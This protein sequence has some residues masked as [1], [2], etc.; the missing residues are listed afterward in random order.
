[1]SD[2]VYEGLQRRVGRRRISQFVN[3]VVGPHLVEKPI[4]FTGSLADAYRQMASD[5]A[6]E[7]EAGEW[8]EGGLSEALP[9]EDFRD[10]PSYPSR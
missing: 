3:E 7:R 4:A 10:W 5:E 2:E 8:I 6:A 9:D 1:V